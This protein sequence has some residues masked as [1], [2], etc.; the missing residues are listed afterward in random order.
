MG[1][2]EFRRQGDRLPRRR[3]RCFRVAERA[4]DRGEIG[5]GVDI[6]GLDGNCL[7]DQPCRRRVLAPRMRDQPE[8]M[9][10]NEM[11]GL[12]RED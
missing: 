6:I 12:V 8:M 5:E 4:A 7:L 10:A 3:E 2:R 9:E 1:L 11:I